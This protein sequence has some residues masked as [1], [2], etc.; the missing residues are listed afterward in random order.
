LA[1]EFFRNILF[2][3]ITKRPDFIA[4]NVLAGKISE[5][6]ILIGGTGFP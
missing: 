4:L 2:F 3:G 5:Y 1:F 6:P